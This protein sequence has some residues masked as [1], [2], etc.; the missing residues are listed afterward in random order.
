MSKLLFYF[1]LCSATTLSAYIINAAGDYSVKDNIIPT[2]IRL[3]VLNAKLPEE[4]SE[5][6]HDTFVIGTSHVRTGFDRC[7]TNSV[8]TRFES[9]M[10]GKKSIRLAKSIMVSSFIEERG[11]LD[12]IIE[13]TVIEDINTSRHRENGILFNYLGTDI[14]HIVDVL[15]GILLNKDKRCD[16]IESTY[17]HEADLKRSRELADDMNDKYMRRLLV[18][19]ITD[20]DDL[21]KVCS[22]TQNATI[23]LVSLPIHSDLYAIEAIKQNF[24]L[25]E[26]Q[27]TAYLSGVQQNNSCDISYLNLVKLGA[28]F[29]DKKFWFDPGHFNPPLGDRV[30]REIE[31]FQVNKSK[32]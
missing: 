11:H 7:S 2:S 20:L 28:E 3:L 24:S 22:E 27:I 15:K 6:L 17:T 19:Y 5:D 26:T 13:A 18:E 12:L 23:T 1:I 8:N 21:V 14:P 29:P 16:V 9:S 31:L 32:R 25:L 4:K 30:I 10:S